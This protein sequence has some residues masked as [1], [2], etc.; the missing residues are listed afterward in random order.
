[1]QYLRQVYRFKGPFA[2]FLLAISGWAL[3]HQLLSQSIDN[4]LFIIK[5]S[6][7]YRAWLSQNEGLQLV[8]IKEII[9]P[10]YQE[11]I[12]ATPNNFTQ[13]KLYKNPTLYLC[14]EAANQLKQ[15]QDSLLTIG[16]S[17][18]VFDAYRP[19]S[20]TQKMWKIVPDERY[21]ANPKNG[22]G[23]N[24]GV[25]I[26]LTLAYATTG[27][28]LEMPTGFDH[29][30][31]SAHHG[32]TGISP[33]K[34]ANRDLLKGIMEHFGFVALSTEWWHYSLPNAKR[35]PLLNLSFKKLRKL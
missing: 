23:H 11:V 8:A 13:Q 2:V 25:S 27:K 22:S 28:A 20:I 29:F 34:A 10:L 35:F 31:D 30:T 7:Q 15:V 16:L 33:E 14:L 1:V 5:S 4:K 32:F 24:R 18:L 21:A 3:P 17:I 6:S 26:D 9:K 19:Y 12:Y